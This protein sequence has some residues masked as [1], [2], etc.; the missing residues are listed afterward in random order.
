MPRS[1]TDKH[2]LGFGVLASAQWEGE[3]GRGVPGGHSSAEKTWQRAAERVAGEDLAVGGR[4]G[5]RR[6]PSRRREDPKERRDRGWERG[7]HGLQGRAIALHPPLLHPTTPPLFSRRRRWA[8]AGPG[9]PME[10]H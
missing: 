1:D 10:A 5:R 9:G 7:R 2:A 3:R 4:E 6:S 8:L